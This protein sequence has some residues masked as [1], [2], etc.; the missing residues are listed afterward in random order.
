MAT[1]RLALE[2]RSSA[3]APLSPAIPMVSEE[4]ES[5]GGQ[6]VSLGAWGMDRVSTLLARGGDGVA[7]E[8]GVAVGWDNHRQ[9]L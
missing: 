2:R 8:P 6:A 7:G 4:A 9:I 1:E 3:R 5:E